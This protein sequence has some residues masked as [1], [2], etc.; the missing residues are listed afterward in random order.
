MSQ[1]LITGTYIATVDKS[2]SEIVSGWVAI[3]GNRI[4]GVGSD[5]IPADFAAFQRID[6]SGCLLT[7]GFVNT[8]HH[9]Y[10][11]ATRGLATESTLFEW[12]ISSSVIAFCGLI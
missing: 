1:L 10:Q 4:V 11:W 8:H 6:G 5:E 2:D 7:P 12:F 3:D 9:L